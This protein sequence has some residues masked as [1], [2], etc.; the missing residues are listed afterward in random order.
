MSSSCS[1]HVKA[2]ILQTHLEMYQRSYITICRVMGL[3][4][5]I[6]VVVVQALRQMKFQLP[7]PG[8]LCLFLPGLSGI[9][10]NPAGLISKLGVLMQGAGSSAGGA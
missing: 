4:Y 5:A 8:R 3:E 6:M 10:R 1:P 9:R 7:Q 2:L